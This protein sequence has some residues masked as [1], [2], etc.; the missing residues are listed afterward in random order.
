MF[1]NLESLTKGRLKYVAVAYLTVLTKLWFRLGAGR[2]FC[3]Y[4]NE[5]S[6]P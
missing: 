2:G 1:L 5:S 6:I 4:S 3:K